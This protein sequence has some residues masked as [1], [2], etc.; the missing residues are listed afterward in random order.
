MLL[1]LLLS[2]DDAPVTVVIVTLNDV[3]ALNLQAALLEF[4]LVEHVVVSV[5]RKGGAG[6]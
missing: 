5:L 4:S 3:D 6:S 1:L 2:D